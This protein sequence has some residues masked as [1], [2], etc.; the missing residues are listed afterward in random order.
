MY[1]MT[2]YALSVL[3][4]YAAFAT[5]TASASIGEPAAGAV[6]AQTVKLP[7]G[8]GS[9]RGLANDATVGGFDGQMTY[10]GADRAPREYEC[11]Q[12]ADFSFLLRRAWAMDRW[13]SVGRWAC[14]GFSVRCGWAFPDT[15]PPMKFSSLVWGLQDDWSPSVAVSTGSRDV[16]TTYASCA[17]VMDSRQ[18]IKTALPMFLGKANRR[19]NNKVIISQPGS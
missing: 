7:S 5:T 13:V 10:C 6:S 11:L 8:P 15:S 18:P 2:R 1:P 3:L 9:V 16:V 14:L 4:T 17:S 19:A 12:T